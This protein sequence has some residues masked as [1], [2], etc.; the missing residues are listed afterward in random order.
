MMPLGAICY[1]LAPSRLA[2]GAAA[3]LSTSYVV[4]VAVLSWTF[5]GEQMTIGKV[6]GIAL[7]VAGVGLLS[8]QQP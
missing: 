5:L 4:L 6:I 2:V 8:A 1:V 3:A 7:T